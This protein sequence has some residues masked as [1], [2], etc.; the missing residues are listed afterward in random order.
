M[1]KNKQEFAELQINNYLR[2]IKNAIDKQKAE[3]QLQKNNVISIDNLKNVSPTIIKE[4][5]AGV[6][7]CGLIDK[8]ES[9]NWLSYTLEEFRL[10]NLY[11]KGDKYQSDELTDIREKIETIFSAYKEGAKNVIFKD[12]KFYFKCNGKKVGVVNTTKLVINGAKCGDLFAGSTDRP[13]DLLTW[14]EVKEV[15]E[16]SQPVKS[17]KP[18]Q[19]T[20]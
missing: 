17:L 18:E 16:I 14:E 1:I 10:I 4:R 15:K 6:V 3:K 20:K 7:M 8:E 5:L 19:A 2:N 11:G 9:L 12:N 13:N